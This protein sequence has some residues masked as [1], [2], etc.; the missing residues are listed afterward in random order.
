M[1]MNTC[2]YRYVALLVEHSLVHWYQQCV[3]IHHVPKC[4]S[5]HNAIVVIT[6][7][8]HCFHDCIYITPILL[9]RYL[10]TLCVVNHL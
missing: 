10:S 7:R 2:T 9:L 1:N 3:T 5:C 4:M 8:V 6:G